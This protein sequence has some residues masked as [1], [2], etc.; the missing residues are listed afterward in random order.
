MLA[1]PGPDPGVDEGP[2]RGVR[3]G[4]MVMR[5]GEM[6]DDGGAMSVSASASVSGDLHNRWSSEEGTV[7]CTS[8]L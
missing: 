2:E 4:G 3:T 1:E 5:R 6:R 7:K 8:A